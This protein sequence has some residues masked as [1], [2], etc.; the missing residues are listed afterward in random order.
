MRLVLGVATILGGFALLR[1]VG[2]F[3]IGEKVFNL[4]TDLLRTMIY[5]NLSI[6]G[7]LTLFTARTK[8]PF[9]SIRPAPILLLAVIGTQIIATFIAVYGFLMPALGW[10]QAGIVWGYSLVMFL[11][12]DF[13]KRGAYRIFGAEH[14]GFYGRHV[15]PE[16]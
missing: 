15:R 1:S 5:L 14:S 11:I 10:T 12:Q 8:G 13:V 2:I 7:H 4:S 6:G 9:W 3:L 16:K